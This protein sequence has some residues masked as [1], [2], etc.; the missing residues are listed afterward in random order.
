MTGT[1]ARDMNTEQFFLEDQAEMNRIDSWIQG[2]LAERTSDRQKH[3]GVAVRVKAGGDLEY[4]VRLGV[5]GKL[6]DFGMYADEVFACLVA[7]YVC[8][9]LLSGRAVNFPDR[10]LCG[11]SDL[12]AQL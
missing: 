11:C 8:S 1:R 12:K 4:Q 6:V 2:V 9:E 5:R 10:R 3:H 7:D